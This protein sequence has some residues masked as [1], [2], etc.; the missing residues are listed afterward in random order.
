MRSKVVT[1]F[2]GSGFIG[3]YVV[4]RLAEHGGVSASRSAGPAARRC[5]C[6]PLGDVGQIDA[7]AVRTRRRPATL[8]A[9]ARRRDCVGQPGR[10]PV[11]EPGGDFDR[12]QAGCRARSAPRGRAAGVERLVQLSAIGAD[13]SS[14]AAY[15]PHQGRGRGGACWRASRAPRSCARASCS[16][17][18]TASSTASPRMASCS[19]VLPLIGGGRPASSRSMSATSPM[20]WSR[21]STRP[22]DGRPDLRAGRSR[23]STASRS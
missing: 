14:P 2:G 15:A 21:R 10:H 5:S 9:A 4:Q 7:R 16:V 19:P 11:R 8:D 22:D 6:K 3:R 20:P 23:G 13:P 12:L 18:R 17:R 1:V